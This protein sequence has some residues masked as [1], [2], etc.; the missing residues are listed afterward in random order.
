M[1]EHNQDQQSD[2]KDKARSSCLVEVEIRTGQSSAMK[3]YDI[4]EPIEITEEENK[5]V[6]RKI[7]RVM[8]PLMGLCYVFSFLDKTILNY[9]SIF[10][11]KEAL[12]LEGTD[13]SWLGRFVL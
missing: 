5:Q 3:V 1:S 9:A 13:Y 10:G 6:K 2:T 12:K 7:D 4:S 11:L 8:L